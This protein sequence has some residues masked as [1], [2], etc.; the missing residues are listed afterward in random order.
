MKIVM[1]TWPLTLL[2]L[3]PFYGTL[4]HGLGLVMGIL[5]LNIF[6]LILGYNYKE[7]LIEREQF[8]LFLLIFLFL[9][10][11]LIVNGSVLM[12]PDSERYL[13]GISTPGSFPERSI[14]YSDII[15]PFFILFGAKGVALIQIFFLSLFLSILSKYVNSDSRYT[16]ILYSTAVIFSTLGFYGILLLPSAFMLVALIGMIL[17]LLGNRNPLIACTTSLFAASHLSLLPVLFI[18]LC[19]Y[20]CIHRPAGSLVCRVGIVLLGSLFLFLFQ[21]PVVAVVSPL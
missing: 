17:I 16:I 8:C 19:I 21:E 1:Y 18:T 9:S 6:F 4:T 20:F 7:N 15:S 11:F 2:I 10:L 12:F 14:I 3:M 13:T 5:F